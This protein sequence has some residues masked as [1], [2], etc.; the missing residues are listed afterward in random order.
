MKGN[1]FCIKIE[2]DEFSNPW[3]R[4]EYLLKKR[5]VNKS[6]KWIN[7][8]N[9]TKKFLL[10]IQIMI[11]KMYRTFQLFLNQIYENSKERY[12]KKFNRVC[13]LNS[14]FWLNSI[15]QVFMVFIKKLSIFCIDFDDM[16]MRWITSI[17]FYSFFVSFAVRSSDWCCRFFNFFNQGWC[18][19]SFKR[20][21]SNIML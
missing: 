19:F 3:P 17:L 13:H 7:C 12:H 5:S 10:D 9:K 16:M 15:L 14:E 20:A 6:V 21:K 1:K 8:A 4:N 11:S 2:N 18:Y